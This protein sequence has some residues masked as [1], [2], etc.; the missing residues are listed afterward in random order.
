MHCIP[1]EVQ[2]TSPGLWRGIRLLPS[3]RKIFTATLIE[4]VTILGTPLPCEFLGFTKHAQ[5]AMITETIRLALQKHTEWALPL[6]VGHVDILKAFDYMKHANIDKALENQR[7]PSRLRAAVLREIA[8][9]QAD[10]SL[11]GQ[12]VPKINY[13]K[14]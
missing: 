6:A 9:M 3:S 14:G 12:H 8:G 13:T 4:L 11:N 5:P 2:A 10:V 1:K 7:V